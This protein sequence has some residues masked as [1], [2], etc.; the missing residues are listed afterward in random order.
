M[1]GHCGLPEC[2]PVSVRRLHSLLSHGGSGAA[3]HLATSIAFIPQAQ[4]KLLKK[5][6]LYTWHTFINQL[7]KIVS[8]AEGLMAQMFPNV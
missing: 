1:F 6:R 7:S 2:G 3:A 4:R 8:I 5:L